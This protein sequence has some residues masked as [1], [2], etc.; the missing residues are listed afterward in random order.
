MA[1]AFVITANRISAIDLNTSSRKLDE[2]VRAFRAALLPAEMQSGK[3]GHKPYAHAS[4][5][6]E[7]LCGEL[8][9]MLVTPVL[10]LLGGC[11][12]LCIVPSGPLH[13]LPFAALRSERYIIED[14]AL[15]YLPSVNALRFLKP[16]APSDV[17]TLA[18]FVNPDCGSAAL[19]LPGAMEEAGVVRLNNR[20]P[21]CWERAR[22]TKENVLLAIKTHD[23]VHLA[24]HASFNADEPM[25]SYLQLASATPSSGRWDLGD[26][27]N[28]AIRASMVTLSACTS[29]YADVSPGE[30]ILSLAY[31]FLHAGTSTVVGSLWKV[32]DEACPALM[33]SYYDHL[34]AEHSAVA[35]AKAQIEML[36]S[37]TFSHPRFWAAFQIVGIANHAAAKAQRAA[38]EG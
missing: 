34:S 29:S 23:I 7:E 9:Q 22:A 25:R 37:T 13:H 26:I 15:S 19:D 32:S 38:G 8:Y 17:K 2:L 3:D 27:L 4:G 14:F 12:T 31:G 30:E 11:K 16:W 33:R 10:P 6:W 20:T 35:L 18:A 28:A 24:C 36:H 1:F 5:S 21:D